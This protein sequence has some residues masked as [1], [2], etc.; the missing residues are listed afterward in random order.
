V[1]VDVLV[2]GAG[3]AGCAA[4]ARLARD[5]AKVA[6]IHR[7]SANPRPSESLPGAAARAL[8]G[9]G[10][11][12]VDTL[13]EGR[14]GGTLS[15]WGSD[16]L[17]ASDAFASPDGPGWWID[18]DRFDRALRRR[19]VDLG[20]GLITGR[21][22]DLRHADGGWAARIAPRT[23]V[24]AR[25]L[26]DATGRAAAIARRLGAVRR[27]GAS[28]LA[29][30]ARTITA[31]EYV[32]ARIFLEAEPDGWWYVGA[33]SHRRISAVTVIDPVDAHRLRY[34]KT[35]V[36]RLGALPNLGRFARAA[37][38]WTAPQVS[39]AGGASLAPVCGEGWIACGDAALAF[40]P[41][42]S[43]GLLGALTSGIAA[44]RAI[45]SDDTSAAFA[46]ITAR[47]THILATYEG[48]R[49]AVYASER[50]WAQRPFWSR[51]DRY[52]V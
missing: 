15:A 13:V 22:H 48:R 41:I 1:N 39:P 33:S 19:C 38:D 30:H 21:A 2:A 10:L 12:P 50:R 46:E 34:R 11:G 5:G 20:V 44:A 51:P 4:A 42:S 27:S 24:F 23:D 35:F 40:D 36:N 26:I 37:T 14:C 3:P 29:L 49:S 8:I 52:A 28:L 9:A 32:P 25:W 17:V 43:Q 6:L 18:R 31:R 16:Q 45:S 7:P 47:D